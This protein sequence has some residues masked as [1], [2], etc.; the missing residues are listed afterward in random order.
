MAPRNRQTSSVVV[1]KPLQS[2]VFFFDISLHVG[3]LNAREGSN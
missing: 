2:L 1:S 3:G